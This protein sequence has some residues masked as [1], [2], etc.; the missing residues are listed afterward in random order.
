M[1]RRTGRFA[2]VALATALAG[3]S[4]SPDYKAPEMATPQR[5]D[6]PVADAGA[7]PS[8]EWW[9]GFGSNEL[10]SLIAQAQLNSTNLKAAVARIRQAQAQAQIAGAALYPSLG[11]SGS[12]GRSHAARSSSA[13]STSASPRAT[14]T[15][16]A[17][18]TAAYQVDLFGTNNANADAAETRIESSLYDRETVALTL[19]SDVATTYFQILS[20]RERRR[21]AEET[22]ENSAS[23]LE[24]LEQRRLAGTISDLEVAQQ[25][26]AVASQRASIPALL[27]AERQ[28]IDALAVLLGRFPQGFDVASRSFDGLNL[29]PVASGLPSELLRRR[30]DIRKA[31]ADLRA[32]NFDIGAARGARYPVLELTYDRGTT[33]RKLSGLFD[34]GTF[35]YTV[36]ASLV[37]PIFEGGRLEGQEFLTLAR[38]EELAELYKTTVFGAF[39]DVEDALSAVEQNASQY[40]FNREAYE[41]A[42]EAYRLADL[43]FR[44][45]TVDFLTVLEA[46]R[47]VF[48]SADSLAV[49]ELS[50]FNALVSLYKALG[51]GWDGTL[52][53]APA[54]R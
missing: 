8:T 4:L 2:A 39:R 16:E 18:L 52:P 41:Q 46:Q 24:L 29:T 10:N 28:S 34:P 43:R 11:A 6:S 14:T 47:S 27:L 26:S 25:R 23:I 21:L 13:S 44:V 19:M 51:G 53:A 1:T 45:G 36:A 9:Q 35:F 20:L 38:F 32:G 49:T 31:E 3:C 22:L 42:R 33:A 15:Y 12:A 17:S 37:T 54:P 40:G 50:R 30:P 5:Y 7:W 48:Q